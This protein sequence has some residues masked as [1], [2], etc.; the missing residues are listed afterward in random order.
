MPQLRGRLS[1]ARAP[2]L[3]ALTRSQQDQRHEYLPASL[4]SCKIPHRTC[5]RQQTSR[6]FQRPRFFVLQP[7]GGGGWS[8]GGRLLHP[9]K[10]KLCSRENPFT[11]R[12]PVLA[13]F[14]GSEWEVAV[15][16]GR[17]AWK[18]HPEREGQ[19]PACSPA[20][21]RRQRRIPG[22]SGKRGLSSLPRTRRPHRCLGRRR[23]LHLC[24]LSPCGVGFWGAMY[25]GR[26]EVVLAAV[27]PLA[28]SSPSS[29]ADRCVLK[30]TRLPDPSPGPHG[31]L[32]PGAPRGNRRQRYTLRARLSTDTC[33]YCAGLDPSLPVAWRVGTFTL[34]LL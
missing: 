30:V 29:T 25:G 22:R 11:A 6:D 24:S 16:G 12:A 21:H 33:L 32:C 4:R 14:S 1:P 18:P 3:P 15:G 17:W 34:W 26:R 31:S 19:G 5:E 20:V 9:C 7:R 13:R 27:R 8:P 2:T 10:P 23:R 28:A